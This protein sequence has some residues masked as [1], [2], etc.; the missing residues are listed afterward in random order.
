ML[1]CLDMRKLKTVGILGGMGPLAG[2]YLERLLIDLNLTARRDQDHAPF[3]HMAI[4]NLPSRVAFINKSGPDP[5]PEMIE[6]LKRLEKAGAACCVIPCNTAHIL[7]SRFS[8]EVK[9]M[10]MIHL[11]K[12]SCDW[13]GKNLKINKIGL[14]ATRETIGF[15]LY[16]KYLDKYGI[17]IITPNNS[18]QKIVTDCI[19][20]ESIGIKA[21]GGEVR[22]ETV[23]LLTGVIRRMKEEDDLRYIIAGC[24]EISVV[25]GE[26][27][28]EDI[29]MI[30]PLHIVARKMLK[31]SGVA[32]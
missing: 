18:D 27:M 8:K 24:T 22:K 12:E 16:K 5:V 26:N 11:I 30:D 9:R 3:V 2:N 4:S 25:F 1:E 28:V 10:K 7:W 20:S 19:F 6:G 21:T 31:Q 17:E 15:G 13:I 29:Q 23:K 14:L 32:M